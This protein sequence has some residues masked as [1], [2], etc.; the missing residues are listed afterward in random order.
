MNLAN[1]LTLFRMF[2]IIPMF[3]IIAL[4]H[5]KPALF[6]FIVGALTD[7]FDGLAARKLNQVTNFGKV[8]DQIADKVFVNGVMIALIPKVPAWLVALFVSRDTVISA[9]RILAANNGV[10]IQ[11]NIYGKAKTFVQMILLIFV[12]FSNA[13][14]LKLEWFTAL[15]IYLSAFLTILSLVI[16]VY[17]NKTALGG[18][19]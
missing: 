1:F 12:L 2:L 18:S 15:L 17:Q 9:V 7:Y 4:G 14:G 19:R 16:Y 13:F 6:L 5:W 3:P 8:F 10:V 11:A